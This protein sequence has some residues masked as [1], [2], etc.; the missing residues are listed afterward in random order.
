MKKPNLNSSIRIIAKK[1]SLSNAK[2]HFSA[3]NPKR[4][5]IQTILDIRSW[6]IRVAAEFYS[7]NLSRFDSSCINNIH[8]QIHLNHLFSHWLLT[9]SF[10]PSASVSMGSSFTWEASWNAVFSWLSARFM[11]LVMAGSCDELMVVMFGTF[12]LTTNTSCKGYMKN[13]SWM[14]LIIQSLTAAKLR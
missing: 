4:E 12:R 3:K 14:I 7:Q 11:T 5:Q 9:S 6:W 1:W 8:F 13:H 10:C 2:Q